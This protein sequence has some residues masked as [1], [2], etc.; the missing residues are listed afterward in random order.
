[1]RMKRIGRYRLRTL[2]IVSL[3]APPVLAVAWAVGRDPAALF[4]LDDAYAQWGAADMVIGYL[5]DHQGDW[6]RDWAALEPYF[7]RSSERVPGWSYAKFQDR[8]H[9]DFAADP[10]RLREL[11]LSAGSDTVPFDVIGARWP[12][13]PQM[14][15]GP[16]AILHGYFRDPGPHGDA[17]SRRTLPSGGVTS[18]R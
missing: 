9:I 2:L 18:A 7:A 5:R 11:S 16:N 10:V 8:I 14:G 15:D 4:D 12:W 13:A 6:P 3:L 1:M 17:A